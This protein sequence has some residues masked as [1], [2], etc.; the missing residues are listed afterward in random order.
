[1]IVNVART[2][3]L[4]LP[5]FL[6]R[7]LEYRVAGANAGASKHELITLDHFIEAELSGCVSRTEVAQLERRIPGMVPWFHVGSMI[8]K[9]RSSESNFVG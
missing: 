1:M 6:I 4:E 9:R 8:S 2:I 7:A 5:E 3:S